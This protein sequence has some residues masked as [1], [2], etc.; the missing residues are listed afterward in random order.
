MISSSSLPQFLRSV[1]FFALGSSVPVCFFFHFFPIFS[2]D[3]SSFWCGCS[4]IRCIFDLSGFGIQQLVRFFGI[5]HC[6]CVRFSWVRARAA[7]DWSFVCVG[8]WVIGS[9]RFGLG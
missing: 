2:L 9:I 3:S 4:V 1:G 7:C 6:L 5:S 8:E